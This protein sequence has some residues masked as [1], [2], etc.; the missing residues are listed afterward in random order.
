MP[1]AYAHYCFGQAVLTRL[2]P[3]KQA[4]IQAHRS[5]FDIGLQGPDLLFN[6]RPLSHDPLNKLGS[7]IHEESA[8]VFFRPAAQLLCRSR[9]SEAMT[10]YL[11]GFLCHF[12]L[13]WHCHSYIDAAAAAGG[14]GHLAME[15]DFDRALLAESGLP[16]C[17]R[18]IAG[19]IR[20]SWSNARLISGL[21]PGTSAR[22]LHGAMT[23]M[24]L[25][26]WF[27]SNQHPLVRSLVSTA[28]K[29]SGCQETFGAMLLYSQP[30]PGC[31]E[32][33]RQLMERY[34]Q[35]QDTAERLIE[36]FRDSARG[37]RDYAPLYQW[38]FN[39]VKEVTP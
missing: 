8:E 1:A 30:N 36:A 23:T 38:N 4:S 10:V 14:P 22:Q 21:F 18:S 3:E 19:C 32:S 25:N 7:R 11:W 27:L 15:A 6:Y 26:Q 20:P 2:P 17:D 16:V 13:D 35:A 31:E 28:L 33:S 29:L 9:D 39:A 12:A 37:L 34:I 5:L 24:R